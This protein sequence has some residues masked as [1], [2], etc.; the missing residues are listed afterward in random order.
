VVGG[1]GN[2]GSNTGV[3]P[4]TERYDPATDTWTT[5]APM[6]PA[7]HGMGAAGFEGRLY[8]PGGATRQGFGAVATFEVFVPAD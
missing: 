7:R 3:F 2:R 1:E 5:L 4:Q 8:V 6:R